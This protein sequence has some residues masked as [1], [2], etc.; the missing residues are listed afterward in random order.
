M[1]LDTTQLVQLNTALVATVLIFIAAYAAPLR[2]S[3]GILLVLIPFQL[4]ETSFASVNVVMTYVLA[5]ALMLRGRLRFAPMLGPVLLVVF[6]YLIVLAQLPRPMYV[7]HGIEVFRL[8]SGFLVFILA[9]NLARET[10]SPRSIVNLLMMMN[11]L[12]VLYCLI[13][14][15]VGPGESLQLFGSKELELNE[16]RGEGDARL[17][18]PFGTP[19]ITAAYFMSLTLILTYEAVYSR[20]W[21]RVGVVALIALNVGMMVATANRGSFL[22]LLAGLLGFLYL[23]RAELGFARIAQILVGSMV[24]LVGATGIVATYTDFGQMF[25]R[26]QEVEVENG[27]PDTRQILWP[28]AWEDI[29][30]R[31]IFGHGPRILGQH[32]LRFTDAHEEQLVGSYPHNLYLHLLLTVG[33]FGTACML[34]FLFY[35]AW[36]VYQGG[37]RGSFNNPYERGWVVVGWLVLAAFL[38][39]E[40]KIEFLRDTTVDYAHFVFALFGLFLGAADGALLK[41]RSTE[42]ISRVRPPVAR[43]ASVSPATASRRGA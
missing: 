11:V 30:E 33:V 12:S 36:R 35:A 1:Y 4:I 41:A 27:I 8:I 22:V 29:N 34:F 19:G 5:G 2:G 39:D 18:G 7:L 17:V 37:R 20:G 9:Y 31:P 38:V 24:V 25:E 3:V 13:Q 21:R 32:E 6:A 14:F 10:E 42:R 26:L 15:S 40:L 23:F 43:P 28:Q 16:N